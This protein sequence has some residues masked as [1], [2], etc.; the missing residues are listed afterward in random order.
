MGVGGWKD[1]PALLRHCVVAVYTKTTGG[2]PDGVVRAFK[3]CRDQL[4]KQGYLY[5]RGQNEILESIQLTG[6]GFVRNQEH[7]REGFPGAVKDKHFQRLFKFI[8]PR[9]WEYDGAGGRSAPKSDRPSSTGESQDAEKAA[10]MDSAESR[11]DLIS[12]GYLM[13]KNIPP[14]R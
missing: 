8:E 1:I 13:P 14:K 10:L 12:G 5:H 11:E 7:S 2:G 6:K 4:A 9:L 3:I